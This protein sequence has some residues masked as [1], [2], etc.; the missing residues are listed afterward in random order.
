MHPDHV[1]PL[2]LGH[3]E[4]HALAQDAGHVDQDVELAGAVQRLPHEVL[5]LS[6]VRD[7]GIVRLGGA[8]RLD[9]RSDDLVG[10][11]GVLALPVHGATEVVDDDRGALGGH[12]LCDA[13]PDAA[14]SAGHDR[15][16]SFE[17]G[18]HAATPPIRTAHAAAHRGIV[19][20][21]ARPR[22][23]C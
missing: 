3:V 12:E 18:S 9:D 6:V 23:V 8:A 17:V 5:G 16:Q 13:A 19:A 15:A 7:V 20:V 11:R 21:G 14:S 4:D 2:V 1:A 10:G 22:R